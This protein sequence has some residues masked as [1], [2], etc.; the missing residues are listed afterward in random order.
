M[1]GAVKCSNGLWKATCLRGSRWAATLLTQHMTQSVSAATHSQCH[2]RLRASWPA[3]TA[4]TPLPAGSPRSLVCECLSMVFWRLGSLTRPL[5]VKFRQQMDENDSIT[6]MLD[7]MSSALS[8]L[9]RGA[10]LVLAPKKS[11]AI[12]HIE[13][14]SLATDRALVVFGFCQWRG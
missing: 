12:K 5:S 11:S 4:R 2:E 13:F 14:V 3:R 6:G 9:T 10:S 8:G 7:R 1:P